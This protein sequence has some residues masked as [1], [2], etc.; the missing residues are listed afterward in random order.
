MSITNKPV[1][2]RK[3]SVLKKY[4]FENMQVGDEWEIPEQTEDGARRVRVA[5]GQWKIRNRSKAKFSVKMY[6]D[7]IYRC[8][9]VK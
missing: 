6:S 8:Q 7:L 2:A 4:D 3:E 1:P 9:R 5:A